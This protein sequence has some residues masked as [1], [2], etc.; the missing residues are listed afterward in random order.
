MLPA[1]DANKMPK[2][3]I[4]TPYNDRFIE[5]MECLSVAK[6]PDG[7]GWMYEIKLDGYRIEVVRD[8]NKAALCSE[9]F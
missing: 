8:D 3:K 6:V 1:V 2:R 9:C 5:P 7:L 4:V